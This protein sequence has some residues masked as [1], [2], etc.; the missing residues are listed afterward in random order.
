MSIRSVPQVVITEIRDAEK[1][2]GQRSQR[3]RHFDVAPRTSQK[4]AEHL[5]EQ[6]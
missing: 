3:G 4:W 5:A 6:S 2:S 1:S